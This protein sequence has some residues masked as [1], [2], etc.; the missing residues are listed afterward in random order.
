MGFFGLAKR[1]QTGNLTVAFS[2]TQDVVEPF[3]ATADSTTRDR[4]HMH[5][6]GPQR[7]SIRKAS[8]LRE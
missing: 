7:P 1:G 6:F 8:P 3:S 5:G 2:Y 4:S